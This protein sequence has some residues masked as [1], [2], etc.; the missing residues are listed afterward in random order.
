VKQFLL[1]LGVLIL[2]A[3]ALIVFARRSRVALL[4]PRTNV[5]QTH[6]GV[7]F[8]I[9]Y[10]D[11]RIVVLMPKEW[12]NTRSRTTTNPQARSLDADVDFF[13]SGGRP[14]VTIE[15]HS[16]SPMSILIDRVPYD[17]GM[18]RVFLVKPDAKSAGKKRVIQAPFSPLAPTREYVKT[19]KEEL[20]KP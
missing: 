19:L 10:Y 13:A 1:I 2:V 15:F 3:V 17:L 8:V 7:M 11:Q 18:G 14:R 16:Y 12:D 4:E 20:D 6:D 5:I 9:E